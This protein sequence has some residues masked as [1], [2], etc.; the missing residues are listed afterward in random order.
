M[1]A[2]IDGVDAV[3]GASV[4]F[5][6]NRESI[7]QLHVGIKGMRRQHRRMTPIKA[8]V[9]HWPMQATQLAPAARGGHT[10]VHQKSLA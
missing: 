2:C 3:V 8:L 10:H 1:G 5:R 9:V 6:A 4:R 7:W